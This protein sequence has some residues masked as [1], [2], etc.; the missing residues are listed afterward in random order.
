MT[1]TFDE[2]IALYFITLIIGCIIISIGIKII[3]TWPNNNIA[4]YLGAS[5]C[6]VGAILVA[7]PI[8]TSIVYFGEKLVFTFIEATEYLFANF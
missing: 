1:W 6:A 4:I 7:A 8:M 3:V 2:I 5:I